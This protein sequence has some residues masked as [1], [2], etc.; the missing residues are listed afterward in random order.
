MEKTPHIVSAVVVL[1][2]AFYYFVFKGFPVQLNFVNAVFA[3]SA[4]FLIGFSFILG[5]LARFSKKLFLPFLHYRKV[6]GLWGYGFAIAH[7][8]AA[9]FVLLPQKEAIT[10]GDAMSL[11][12][13]AAAITIFTLMALTST[14]KW[15]EKLGYENWKNLQRI[16]YIA[17][18]FVL[19][20][21]LLLENGVLLQR[22]IG[23]IAIAF[24]LAVFLLRGIAQVLG[25]PS[26]AKIKV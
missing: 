12:V 9:T 1:I 2:I 11:A 17:Y 26:P 20:H 13:A 7:I 6:F 23:Q 16:G 18:A 5:P 4:L 24:V 8:S 10:F 25:I 21:M 22:Q 15:M 19:F 3:F 14:Q